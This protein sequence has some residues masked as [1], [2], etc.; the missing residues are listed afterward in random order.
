MEN[1]IPAYTY[2]FSGDFINSLEFAYM[3]T[4][5]FRRGEKYEHFLNSIKREYD[6]LVNNKELSPEEIDRL[7]DLKQRLLYTQ[8]LIN[9]NGELYPFSEHTNT[10]KRNSQEVNRIIE[11]FKTTIV[12]KV[13]LLC[14]PEYRDGI[15]FYNGNDEIVAT[16][17]I[18]LSCAHM[19][20]EPFSHVNADI[21]VYDLLKKFFIDIGH[22]LEEPGR[23]FV[24]GK[25]KEHRERIL[26]ERRDQYSG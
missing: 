1:N 12:E 10:F 13:S 19:E 11:I 25:M 9:K 8:Y 6:Q 18:C 4:Y 16:L 14:A 17:N 23:F 26:N 22:E 5:S 24:S 7:N 2:T 21:L 15:I 3:K 20:L